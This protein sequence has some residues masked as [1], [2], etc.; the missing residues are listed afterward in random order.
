[1]T[2]NPR[3]LPESAGKDVWLGKV[4]RVVVNERRAWRGMKCGE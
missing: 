3:L 4:R 1:M 2:A